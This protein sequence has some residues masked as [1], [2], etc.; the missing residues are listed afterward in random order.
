SNNAPRVHMS[1]YVDTEDPEGLIGSHEGPI[2]AKGLVSWEVTWTVDREDGDHEVIATVVALG[3]VEA[4]YLDNVDTFEFKIGPRSYPDPEPLDITIYPDSTLVGPGTVIQVSGKVTLAKNGFEVPD[5]TVYIQVRGQDGH[6]EV[7]T[8]DLG[9][10]LANVTVPNKVGNYRMEAQV[11]LGLS[12]GDNAITITVEQETT[13]PNNGGGEDGLSLSYFIISLIVVLAV[14]MP[15]TYYI[16]VSRTAI[17]RRV[18]HVHEEIVE[19]VEDE[20]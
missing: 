16:L 5:A 2:D 1:V 20:K 11:R 9:R 7:M 4:T 14:L 3:E 18:R 10:Y 13:N 15:L 19:I 17:R 8:N 12:E 6:V